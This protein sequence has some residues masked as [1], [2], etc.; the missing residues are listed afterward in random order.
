MR[1]IVTQGCLMGEGFWSV[2]LVAEWRE[3]ILVIQADRALSELV[4]WDDLA[5]LGSSILRVTWGEKG[6]G[7]GSCDS[8][9]LIQY[10][11]VAIL[12]CVHWE[13]CVAPAAVLFSVFLE[14]MYCSVLLSAQT[15]QTLEV[16]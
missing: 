10:C 7:K 8:L 5:L 15:K 16:L 4:L 3:L 2:T 13:L 11:T 9:L 6:G 1:L 12:I 14:R